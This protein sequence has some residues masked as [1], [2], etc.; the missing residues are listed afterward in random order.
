MISVSTPPMSLG[1]TKKTSV[2]CAPM[3]G[4][5]STRAPLAFELG[6]GRV[7]VGHLEADVV[8]TAERVLLEEFHDR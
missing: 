6:L 4:S 8:L 3:R 5:P 1:W 2:P 7:D